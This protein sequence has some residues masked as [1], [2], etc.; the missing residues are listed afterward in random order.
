[1][2]DFDFN[3]VF[4]GKWFIPILKELEKFEEDMARTFPEYGFDLIDHAPDWSLQCFMQGS[5]SYSDYHGIESFE[6]FGALRL[7]KVMGAKW[8]FSEGWSRSLKI[9]P[10]FN[11]E[12]IQKIEAVWGKGFVA[13]VI[14]FCEAYSISLYSKFQRITRLA[15][16]TTSR[17]GIQEVIDYTIGFSRGL[18]TPQRIRQLLAKTTK[19]SLVDEQ[20]R[21]GVLGFGFFMGK[22]IEDQKAELSWPQVSDLFDEFAEH[23]VEVDQDTMKK[24]LQRAG[25]KGVGKQ[26]RK[27]PVKKTMRR[28]LRP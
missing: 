13:D 26:G 7:G 28:R 2:S 27:V 22:F 23:K 14:E 3:Q 20:K 11:R 16:E 18:Q 17:E 6:G 15:W 9:F 25:L 10:L 21:L 5:A 4:P 1:M 8:A 24:I 12:Q 19:K